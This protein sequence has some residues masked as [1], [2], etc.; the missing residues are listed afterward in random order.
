MKIRHT[1]LSDIPACLELYE[2]ARGIMRASGNLS[3]WTN[4]YPSEAI[5]RDDIRLGNSYV[6]CDGDG[7]GDGYGYVIGT[8]ACIVGEDPTYRV[9]EGGSWLM[10]E[11]PYATIHRLASRP[12][13]H[14][15]ARA[16]F[17]FAHTLAPSLRADTH[18]DNLIMQ[19]I[20]DGY[21]FSRRGIIHLINGDPRI[22][23]QLC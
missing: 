23:Y 4:G 20:L 11:L 18:A 21:G 17:D 8:F 3:Q 12:E 10:P 9:I 22:A 14:G 19:H 2:A 1:I 6:I 16:T 5:L 13:S 15:I 7:N